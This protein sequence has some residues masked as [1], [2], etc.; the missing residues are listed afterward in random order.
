MKS[1]SAA[2]AIANIRLSYL[3]KRRNLREPLV[4]LAPFSTRP[5]KPGSST[6]NQG[7]QVATIAR[8]PIFGAGARSEST[9]CFFGS[10]TWVGR[11]IPYL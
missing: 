5:E 9:H 4:N 7:F 1:N 10:A 3:I 11:T 6:K 2:K 8:N